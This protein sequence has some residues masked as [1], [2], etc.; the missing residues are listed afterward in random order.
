[1]GL[2]QKTEFYYIKKVKAAII[3]EKK[4]RI[5]FKT[6]FIGFDVLGIPV[7]AT[8]SPGQFFWIPA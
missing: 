8:G 7:G 4:T 5:V 3:S 1:L 2:P 6:K